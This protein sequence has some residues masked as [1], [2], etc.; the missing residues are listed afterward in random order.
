MVDRDVLIDCD[1]SGGGGGGDV[2]VGVVDG[3]GGGGDV[4]VGIGV[5]VVDGIGGGGGDESLTQEIDNPCCVPVKL[6]PHSHYQRIAPIKG[7][8]PRIP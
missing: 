4:D 5:G 7:C 2:G 6:E 1:P 3:I 8:F